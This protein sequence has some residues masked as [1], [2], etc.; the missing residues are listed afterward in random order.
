[1]SQNTCKVIS[2]IFTNFAYRIFDDLNH[3]L[4]YLLC[5]PCLEVVYP[6]PKNF[7]VSFI[8]WKNSSLVKPIIDFPFAFF[9]PLFTALQR[10]WIWAKSFVWLGADKKSCYSVFETNKTLGSTNVGQGLFEFH[11]RN[12]LIGNSYVGASWWA[13]ERFLCSYSN[14]YQLIF[15]HTKCQHNRLIIKF[16]QIGLPKRPATLI[17][18][19]SIFLARKQSIWWPNW[20]QAFLKIG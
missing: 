9:N 5:N 16:P 4:T 19:I 7:I 18:T 17:L 6:F 20:L 2:C 11:H 10:A 13:W 14:I 1:M 15:G 3:V 12:T 8:P